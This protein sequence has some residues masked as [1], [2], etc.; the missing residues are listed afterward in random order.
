MWDVRDDRDKLR[1]LMSEE[2][3]P[4]PIDLTEEES[5]EGPLRVFMGLFLVPLAVILVCVAVFVGFGWVA[6]EHNTVAD[7][8]NDLN[9][10]W[11]PRRAQAAYELSKILIADP[12]ALAGDVAAQA[13]IRR[14][15][16]EADDD[17]MRRYLA[18]V[19]GRT[20]DP[21]AVALLIGALDDPD[22]QT[23]IYILMALG[24]SG[25]RRALEPLRTALS[26][27]DAG[28]RKTAAW[29]FGELGEVAAAGDLKPLLTDPEPDVRWNAA[30]ALA[31]L[32]SDSGVP[33]LQE[34]LDRGLTGQA[35]EITTAQQEEAMVQ[36]VRA[37]A[38]VG[39]ESSRSLL[40]D[41]ATDDPSL[42][43]RQAALE[44]QKA[45]SR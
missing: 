43:V 19:M 33:V 37:L 27:A 23:R 44:A 2:P 38:V 5:S 41:L 40:A 25:D 8:L 42:K 11:R 18:L 12:E 28:L 20:G 34:M 22:S 30:L 4:R 24:Q 35:P 17:V 13:E 6:Y 15:F 31:R 1:L 21:E 16:E 26:D 36:A 29:S 7:Y 14:Q 32:G 45:L 9:S 10:S 39:G 3:S